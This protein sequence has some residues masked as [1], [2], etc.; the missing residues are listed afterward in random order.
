[1]RNGKPTRA[2]TLI[3]LLLVIATIALLASLLLP[4]LG[5]IK[6]RMRNISCLNNLKQ[7]GIATALYAAENSEALPPEG[8]PNPSE[9]ST[10]SGW[11]IQLPRQLNLTPYHEMSWRTNAAIQPGC[12]LWIC[13]DNPRR[14]NGRNLFHYCLNEH[15][16]GSGR[17]TRAIQL[18]S[19]D[20][21]SAV[22][23]LFDSKNL[24]AVGYWAFVHTN[25]HNR[26]AQFL[27]LDGHT[28][29][30]PN[31]AYWDFQTDRATT[32]NPE[33]IWMP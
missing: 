2:F 13:P 18:S 11:Y 14:S 5:G 23:W 19:I 9:R 27:F 4:P 22:P 28:R 30:F 1:M 17:E 8:V 21:P 33:L 25:L 12:S 6:S 29:R 3:E 15:V 16:N 24:P 31:T 32:N 10:N 7:W 20:N 26:G